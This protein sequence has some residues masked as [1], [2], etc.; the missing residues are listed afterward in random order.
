MK[1]S[2]AIHHILFILAFICLV[3]C[4]TVHQFGDNVNHDV[5]FKGPAKIIQ[6]NSQKDGNTTPS[7]LPYIIQTVFYHLQSRTAQDFPALLS[8]HSTLN[9]SI[10]SSVR[11]IL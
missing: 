5:I 6:K 3:M 11:L 9:L 10:V 1:A 8:S 2:R 7:Q 4:P